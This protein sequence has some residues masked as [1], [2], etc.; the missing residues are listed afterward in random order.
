M[1]YYRTLSAQT[2]VLSSLSAPFEIFVISQANQSLLGGNV[3][4]ADYLPF[5]REVYL[6]Q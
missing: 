3:T 6:K 4:P 5:F 2:K 1:E